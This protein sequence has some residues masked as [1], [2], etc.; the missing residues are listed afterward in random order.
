MKSCAIIGPPM[1]LSIYMSYYPYYCMIYKVR[2]DRTFG[3]CFRSETD[4]TH[5]WNTKAKTI[6]KYAKKTIQTK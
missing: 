1:D 4:R 6:E 5:C 2:S 3:F